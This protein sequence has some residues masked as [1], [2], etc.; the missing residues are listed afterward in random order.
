MYRL[1]PQWRTV[2]ELVASDR[3][4]ELQAIQTVFAYHN[5]DPGNIRNVAA[6]GGGALYDIGCYAI[7][8][9]RMMF[10]GEPTRVLAAARHDDR[11]GTDALTSAVLDFDGRHA[12]FTCSTQLEPAQRV[13]LL[14]TA[15]RLIV[16]IPFNIPPDRPTRLRLVAGGEPP[17][18]PH[19]EVIEVPPA[20][21]YGVQAEAFSSAVRGAAP[22][23]IAPANAVANLE[24]IEAIVAAAGGRP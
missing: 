11:F 24:V 3:I 17:T 16:E 21:Q 20:D 5:V 9:A 10:G 1:H 2:V 6:M 23:P 8:V 22:V 15:G 7:D 12:T 4:G 18:D 19:V 14:G 13:E